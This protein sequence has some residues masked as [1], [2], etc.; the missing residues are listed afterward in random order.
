MIEAPT[1]SY[2]L[3]WPD[4]HPRTPASARQGGAAFKLTFGVYMRELVDEVSRLGGTDLIVSTNVR[5]KP[6]GMPYANER[7]PSDPGVAVYFKWNGAPRA[8][9]CDRYDEVRKN[10]RGITLCIDALRA[11]ERH[12]SSAILERAFRGF[13]ALPAS[14]SGEAW[15]TVLGV[16]HSA[17]VEDIRAAYR[18][19]ALEAHPDREGGSAAAFERVKRAAD[20][21][22]AAAGGAS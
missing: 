4:G 2:P 15:W 21:G 9:A 17:S 3:T 7:A 10:I 16:S 5:S 13:T 1:E 12:G 22:L 6:N 8:M 18:R 19:A 14:G 11:L 20:E